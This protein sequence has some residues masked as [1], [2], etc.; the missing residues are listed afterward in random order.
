MREKK[1]ITEDN[2]SVVIGYKYNNQVYIGADSC[3]TYKGNKYIDT[4]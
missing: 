3:I 4:N 1:R 2:M